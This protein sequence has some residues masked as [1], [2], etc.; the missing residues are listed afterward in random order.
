MISPIDACD[1]LKKKPIS[2]SDINSKYNML[3]RKLNL[4]TYDIVTPQSR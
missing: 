4:Q 3:H 1:T 2:P